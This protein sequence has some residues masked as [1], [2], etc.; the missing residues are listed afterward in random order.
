MS[1]YTLKFL[2]VKLDK[3]FVTLL[4]QLI[5]SFHREKEET[6]SLHPLQLCFLQGYNILNGAIVISLT[7]KIVVRITVLKILWK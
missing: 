3:L 4:S 7:V 6:T 2:K 5:L 1:K